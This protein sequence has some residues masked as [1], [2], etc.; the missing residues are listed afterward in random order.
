MAYLSGLGGDDAL[1]TEH[2]K[3]AA[4]FLVAHGP[5]YGVERWE[6]QSGY[7]PS[8]IAAEI[9]GLTA[10][11]AIAKST[12]TPPTRAVYQATADDFQRNVQSWTVTSTGPDSS[13]PVLHPAVQD[14]RPE[15]RDHLQPEQRRP[16]G[17]RRTP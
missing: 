3:P 11:A 12:T 2:I 5:S 10:A 8:T 6:E 9:A 13:S 14:R 4:D 15:R 16:H 17:A 1:W 7:S